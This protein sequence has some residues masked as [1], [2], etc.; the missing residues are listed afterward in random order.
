MRPFSIRHDDMKTQFLAV[1]WFINFLRSLAYDLRYAMMSALR[2]RAGADNYASY[3][4]SKLYPDYLKFGAAWMWGQGVG[5]F[6]VRA[7]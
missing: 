4:S 1:K 7:L 2:I 6:L 3:R 5:R